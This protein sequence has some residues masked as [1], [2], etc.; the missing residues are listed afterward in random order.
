[1]KERSNEET[2]NDYRIIK[3]NKCPQVSLSCAGS[4]DAT[5]R[6]RQATLAPP[7][8]VRDPLGFP[9]LPGHHNSHLGCR[10]PRNRVNDML[11]NR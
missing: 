3:S 2:V 10:T 7:L 8:L 5:L 4:D 6:H 11:S 1:M 9:H